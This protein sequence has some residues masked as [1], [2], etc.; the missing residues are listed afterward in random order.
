MSVAEDGETEI[1]ADAADSVSH[2]VSKQRVQQNAAAENAAKRVFEIFMIMI[3]HEND[4]QGNKE[5]CKIVCMFFFRVKKRA[6][7]AM[8]LTLETVTLAAVP[9]G[10]STSLAG[11][12][13]EIAA[14]EAQYVAVTNKITRQY[15]ADVEMLKRK[16]QSEGL[17][18]EYLASKKESERFAAAIAG[19]PDPFEEIP[20]M[21]FDCIV[22]KP[23]ALRTLQLRYL[24]S[25]KDARGQKKAQDAALADRLLKRIEAVQKELTRKGQID[26]AIETRN[27]AEK[28]RAAV[29]SGK[30]GEIVARYG[31]AQPQEGAR[32]PEPTGVTAPQ[33]APDA[34]EQPRARVPRPQLAATA[35]ANWSKWEFAG[36]RPFSPE[37][38]DLFHPDLVSPIAA[39]NFEKTGRS[40]FAAQR[41]LQQ[42]QQVGG[43]LCEW[44]GTALEWNVADPSFLPTKM[45]ITS[46]KVAPSGNRGPK[47]FIYV[48]GGIP[49]IQQMPVELMQDECEIRIVRDSSDPTHFALYWQKA[50]R[51]EDFSIADGTPVKVVI[52]VALNGPYQSCD[53]TVQFLQQ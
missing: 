43:V 25:I 49:Q 17:L 24:A 1:D 48:I 33:A 2:P 51:R 8:A 4:L 12:A 16:F 45:K 22:S 42:G 47:L 36:E 40:V 27:I 34:G 39:R 37:L 35:G 29:M 53:T 11:F 44:S 41:G 5:K 30:T 28:I 21:P 9:Q 38:R 3:L 23:E 46:D 19:N 20:E 13:N 6:L 15:S 14:N 32:T 7:F 52:G 10:V 31:I 26:E 18:D 50:R